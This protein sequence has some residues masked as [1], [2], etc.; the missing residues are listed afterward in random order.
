MA[1]V[2]GEFSLR[3]AMRQHFFTNNRTLS[4]LAGRGMTLNQADLGILRRDMAPPTQS[5]MAQD[6]EWRKSS[7]A[8]QAT[9]AD[10]L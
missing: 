1:C 3:E 7:I 9:G 5:N 2:L 10:S 6:A 8:R 4:D